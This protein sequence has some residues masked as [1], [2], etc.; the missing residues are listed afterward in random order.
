MAQRFRDRLF[1]PLG[2]AKTSLPGADDLSLLAPCSH[3]YMYGGTAYALVDRPYPAGMQG[4]GPLRKV[5][6]VDYTHQNRSC[7]LSRGES[8]RP[9]ERTATIARPWAW[10]GVRVPTAG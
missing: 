10:S 2:L 5:P 3:G 7:G 1:A 8:P 6:P 9:Y 4:G